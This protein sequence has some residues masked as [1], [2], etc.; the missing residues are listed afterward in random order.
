MGI[1][2]VAMKDVWIAHAQDGHQYFYNKV[3]NE[4]AWQVPP[5]ASLQEPERPVVAQSHG[6]TQNE[7]SEAAAAAPAAASEANV[8]ASASLASATLS[9]VDASSDLVETF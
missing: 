5:G 2:V 3:T 1:D 8:P 9:D 6:Q 4:T 7:A